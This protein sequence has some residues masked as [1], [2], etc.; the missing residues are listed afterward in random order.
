MLFCVWTAACKGARSSG[1]EVSS[2][3]SAT[4][5]ALRPKE[6]S[7]IFLHQFS[8]RSLV[9][10]GL[11]CSV[12]LENDQQLEL[13]PVSEARLKAPQGY[14]YFIVLKEPLDLKSCTGNNEVEDFDGKSFFVSRLQ[15]ELVL[16]NTVAPA[17]DKEVPF[18]TDDLKSSKSEALA[19]DMERRRSGGGKSCGLTAFGNRGC[20]ACVGWAMTDQGLFPRGLGSDADNSPNGF[21]RATASARARKTADGLVN[22]NGIRF[23]S[24]KAQYARTPSLAPRGSIL[25]CNTSAEGHAAVVI[26]PAEELRSDVVEILSSTWRQSKCWEQVEEI[27]FPVD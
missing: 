25:F 1:S 27:L 26:K 5:I 15:T 16:S 9:R 18:S 8:T 3:A 11:E 12:K 2:T 17:P 21:L 24:L 6:N 20:W 13:V 14:E 22:I 7:Y 23:R 4:V 10:K 19:R